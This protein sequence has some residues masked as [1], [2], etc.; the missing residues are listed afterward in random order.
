MATILVIDDDPVTLAT[1]EAL[2][3]R[4]GHDVTTAASGP[5]GI[6]RVLAREPDLVV[7][8]IFMPGQDGLETMRRIKSLN[9][10]GKVVCMSCGPAA[11]P[12]A[13]TVRDTMLRFARD[14]GAD[15]VI[16]KPLALEAL[17]QVVDGVLSSGASVAA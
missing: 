8:D 5:E 3:T 2:L 10:L 1:A 11:L 16:A 4:L 6:G 9:P 13:V 14:C 7:T 17:R 12:D 15:G